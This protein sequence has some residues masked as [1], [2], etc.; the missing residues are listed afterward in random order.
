MQM[1]RASKALF[2]ILSFLQ[3]NAGRQVPEQ[4]ERFILDGFCGGCKFDLL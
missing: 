1:Q 4:T 3:P 2:M